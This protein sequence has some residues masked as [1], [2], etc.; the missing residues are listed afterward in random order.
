MNALLPYIAGSWFVGFVASTLFGLWRSEILWNGIRKSHPDVWR[1]VDQSHRCYRDT[2]EFWIEIRREYR[3]NPN[4]A[5]LRQNVRKLA[6]YSSLS[7]LWL[8]ASLIVMIFY[9]LASAFLSTWAPMTKG[10]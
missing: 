5:A 6:F 9:I 8:L 10:G 3:R 4:D 1:R 2:C 7:L